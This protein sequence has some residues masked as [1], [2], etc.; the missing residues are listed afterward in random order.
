MQGGQSDLSQL[1]SIFHHSHLWR[2]LELYPH[3]Q[4]QY[5]KLASLSFNPQVT[6]PF[7][8]YT[9]SRQAHSHSSA[10]NHT[11]HTRKHKQIH[12]LAFYQAISQPPI[13]TCE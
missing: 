7:H 3:I 8:F 10:H 6:L 1:A 2:A 11:Y 4:T 12:S 5:C 13:I 9:D